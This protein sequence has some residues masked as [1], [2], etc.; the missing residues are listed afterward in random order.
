MLTTKQLTW[1][2]SEVQNGAKT[3]ALQGPYGE[4]LQKIRRLVFY[5]K[6]NGLI[7]FEFA[8][9]S[10]CENDLSLERTMRTSTQTQGMN[11]SLVATP[12]CRHKHKHEDTTQ[13]RLG[14]NRTFPAVPASHPQPTYVPPA[15]PHCTAAPAVQSQRIHAARADARI[16]SRGDAHRAVPATATPHAL[17]AA[18]A[19]AAATA[20]TV[21]L[22]Q[23]RPR[24]RQAW[25][26]GRLADSRAVR[27]ALQALQAPWKGAGPVHSTVDTRQL[28]HRE[29]CPGHLAAGHS[30]Q[31]WG[32]PAGKGTSKR[33]LL[34]GGNGVHAGKA[35]RP[36]RVCVRLFVRLCV[37][38]TVCC[39]A[40]ACMFNAVRMLA[41]ER[42]ASKRRFARFRN[43]HAHMRQ[44]GGSAQGLHQGTSSA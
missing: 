32:E 11:G 6:V 38:L 28:R 5:N 9:G 17:A 14:G 44:E 18:A 16:S 31:Q 1:G 19:A 3:G 37:F 34:G 39:C 40:S 22:A 2:Q 12:K 13:Q 8:N 21:A 25:V 23:A 41:R 7:A 33:A 35:V 24:S 30:R 27:T 20:I 36:W 4:G 29:G 42:R 43:V 10:I 15:H 26:R